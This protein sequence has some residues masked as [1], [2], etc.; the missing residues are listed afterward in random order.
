MNLKKI[1]NPFGGMTY[2][3]ES[4]T[5]TM[6]E[7]K[8]LLSEDDIH[9]SLVVADFQTNGLGRIPGRE[10]LSNAKENLTFT[11]I[12]HKEKLGSG[13]EATASTDSFALS[14]LGALLIV[15]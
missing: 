11:L 3:K 9:G 12:L 7:A 4:T 2:Y 6:S 5:S 14:L 1:Q 8:S 15:C 10:W 13:Y